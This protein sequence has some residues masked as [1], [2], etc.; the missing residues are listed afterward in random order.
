M[1]NLWHHC[2]WQTCHS[3]T[4]TQS[5]SNPDFPLSFQLVNVELNQLI[6]P[7][8]CKCTAIQ[9]DYHANCVEYQWCKVLNKKCF[10]VHLLS[11]FEGSF[12][13]LFIFLNTFTTFFKK[14]LYFLLHTFSLTPKITNYSLNTQQDRKIVK[15]TNLSTEHPW[16]SLLPL[17]WWTH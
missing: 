9:L 10:K 13:L 6:F 12:T 15:F 8:L 1:S 5:T 4:V 16:S 7:N 2:G 14:I 11:N 3:L 17:I